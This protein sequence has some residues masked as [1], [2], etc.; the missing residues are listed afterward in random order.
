M[1]PRSPCGRSRVLLPSGTGIKTF[2]GGR[3][4]SDYVSFRRTI[5]TQ[6]FHT[7]KHTIQGK[8]QYNISLKKKK[9]RV[10]H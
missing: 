4:P 5:K 7:L 1:E 3:E 2:C 10:T 6:R 8:E 9:K